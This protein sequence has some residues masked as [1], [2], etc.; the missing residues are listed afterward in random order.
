[1]IVLIGDTGALGEDM[2]LADT[3][4]ESGLAAAVVVIMVAEVVAMVE[5]VME[6][7]NT[8]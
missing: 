4:A 2:V 8:E 7:I 3:A 5:E 6:D 1:M